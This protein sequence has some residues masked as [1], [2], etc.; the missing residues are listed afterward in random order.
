MDGTS[1]DR[2]SGGQLFREASLETVLSAYPDV[3]LCIIRGARATRE[4]GPDGQEYFLLREPGKPEL[5]REMRRE[6][7]VR[8][9][10]VAKKLGTVP[11][12]RSSP[13]SETYDRIRAYLRVE[14]ADRPPK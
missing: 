2:L 7:F 3:V 6:D 14:F 4:V 13:P 1:R 9:V 12:F 5:A 8:C 11:L 10:T